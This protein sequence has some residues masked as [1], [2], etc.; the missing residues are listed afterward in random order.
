MATEKQIWARK[1]N[2]LIRRLLG[3]KSIFS[4]DNV[5]FMEDSIKENSYFIDECED[6][7]NELLLVL[8]KSSYK[9]KFTFYEGRKCSK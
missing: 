7:I 6:A 2:W 8:R 5:V 9:S 4:H 1:R 3:A